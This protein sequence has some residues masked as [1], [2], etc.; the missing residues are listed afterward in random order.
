VQVCNQKIRLNLLKEGENGR[1]KRACAEQADSHERKSDC[2]MGQAQHDAPQRA[3]A[4][5]AGPVVR[6]G[7][8]TNEMEEAPVFTWA[9]G[10]S[11]FAQNSAFDYESVGRCAGRQ[12]IL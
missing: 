1:G 3:T 4:V 8:T 6:K 7:L 5:P 9:D 12:R 2:T 10:R 11:R